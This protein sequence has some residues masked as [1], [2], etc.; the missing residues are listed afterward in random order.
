MSHRPPGRSV[1]VKSIL[2]INYCMFSLNKKILVDITL[3]I[4]QNFK[5]KLFSFLSLY[6]FLCLEINS[7]QTTKDLQRLRHFP[8]G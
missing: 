3:F 1:G 5:Q 2:V 7:D 4:L 8:S 6:L